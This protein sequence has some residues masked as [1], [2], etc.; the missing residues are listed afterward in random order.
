M[1]VLGLGNALVDII[2]HLPNDHI[3]EELDLPKASMQLIDSSWLQRIQ[4]RLTGMETELVSGGS[5]ANTIH[6]L[7]NLGVNTGFMGSIGKDDYGKFFE[8]DIKGKGIETVLNYSDSPSG[9]AMALVSPDSERTFGTFLGAALELAPEHIVES[10]FETYDLL[11]IEGYLVQNHDLI[12]KAVRMARNAGLE[13]SIDLAS[14]NVVEDNREFLKK[15]LKNYVT[16]VF[17]NEEEAKAMT[18]KEPEEALEELYQMCGKAIV[19]VGKDGSWIKIRNEEVVH[20]EAIAATPVDT[21]GAGDSYASGFIYGLSKGL[22]DTQCG[23]IGSIL[24]GKVI[25]FTGPKIPLSVWGDVLAL[26][27]RVESTD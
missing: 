27:K 3:L 21:S 22:T 25:E 8:K 23:Q 7:S 16:I 20:V 10:I 15:I 19:K 11:H 12:E 17:A 4:S 14:Y 9:R 18:G 2:I 24:A 6:G 5:A 13:V 26:V 1:K